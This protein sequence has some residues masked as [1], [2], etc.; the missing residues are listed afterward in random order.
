MNPTKYMLDMAKDTQGDQYAF[1]ENPVEWTLQRSVSGGETQGKWAC[2]RSSEILQSGLYL[3][4]QV[5]GDFDSESSS[6]RHCRQ[7]SNASVVEVEVT[8]V[9]KGNVNRVLFF[10]TAEVVEVPLDDQGHA[11]ADSVQ[12]PR[13]L[14]EVVLR[15]GEGCRVRK[16]AQ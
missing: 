3:A 5:K 2:A 4:G 13:H 6:C 9:E 12:G 15:E 11:D 10:D 16:S 1:V 14:I 7:H 8:N